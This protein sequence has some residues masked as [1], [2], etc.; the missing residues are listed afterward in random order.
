VA[1]PVSC[2]GFFRRHPRLPSL[3]PSRTRPRPSA[4][5]PKRSAEL[6][7]RRRESSTPTSMPLTQP[8]TGSNDVMVSAPFQPS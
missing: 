5:W 2:G 4:S 8:A 7:I 3:K 1:L 6:I